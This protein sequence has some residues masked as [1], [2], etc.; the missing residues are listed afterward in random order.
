MTL[1]ALK[2][3]N[4]NVNVIRGASNTLPCKTAL[5]TGKKAKNTLM[6]TLWRVQLKQDDKSQT[7]LLSERNI[8]NFEKLKC[9]NQT[10]L[11]NL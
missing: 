6:L 5:L 10:L 4:R 3:G 8:D 2:N 1:T 9:S 7:K 11:H